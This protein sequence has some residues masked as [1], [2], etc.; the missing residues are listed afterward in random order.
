MPK[1]KVVTW[2]VI[3]DGAKARIVTNRGPGLNLSVD[4]EYESL[5]ARQKEEDL[6]SDRKGRTFDSSGEGRH[7]MEPRTSPKQVE[8]NKFVQ[9]IIEQVRKGGRENAF[10][11]LVL[12]AAP[13]VMGQLRKA[14]SGEFGERITHEIAKDLTN[15]A[16]HDLPSHLESIRL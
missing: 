9:S 12:I 4:Q 3:T 11:R 6:V 10:D 13:T 2:I 1:K 14:L 16:I 5:A 15:V 7:A 8:K